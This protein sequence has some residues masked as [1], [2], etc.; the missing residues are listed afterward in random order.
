MLNNNIQYINVIKSQQNIKIDY[1]I[2]K[3]NQIIKNEHSI[4]LLEEN[5]LSIDTNYKL[6]TLENN[7]P[8]TY[9]CAIC[10]D[11]NQTIISNDNNTQNIYFNKTHSITLPSSNIEKTKQFYNNG[12]IDYLVSP[13]T[14]LQN[15]LNTNLHPNSLNLLILNNNIYSIL[16]DENKQYITSCI[17]QLTSFEDIQNSDFYTDEIVE[18]KLYDEIYNLELNE[19]ISNITNQ[20]YKENPDAD[21]IQSINIYYNIKQLNDEQLNLLKDN[22]MIETIYNPISLN[23]LLYDM[24]KRSSIKKQSFIHPRPKKST[25]SLISWILI[26]LITTFLAGALFY[27]MQSPKEEI[28]QKEIIKEKKKIVKKIKEIQL[29]NHINI[30]EYIVNSLLDIFETISDDSLLKEIQVEQNESTLIYN[31][32]NPNSYEST[33]KPK[34]LK[35]YKKSENVLTSKNNFTYTAIISNTMP[36][37]KLSTKLTKIY[38]KSS[39]NKY[40]EKKEINLLLKS[41]FN[42]NSKIKNLSIST[43]KYTISRYSITTIVKDPQEFF[44]T[45]DRLDT[46]NYS[47][48]LSYPIEFAKVKDNLEVNFKLQ[49][50]QNN[51][52]AKR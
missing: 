27:I 16:L 17:K 38:P 44:T 37:E 50:N 26:A 47:I 1:Q 8:K 10:E 2:I 43:A 25:L 22:L 13:F 42:T 39:Q 51:P 6:Q 36:K 31:F 32:K 45:I 3:E 41:I 33:L 9:I 30:N 5:K 4:F 20:F 18:Q 21:F 28:K 23:E 40:L 35:I 52:N 34:L 46:L 19:N 24:V 7:I 11:K 48:H 49:I 12:N 29:P 15:I 14:I